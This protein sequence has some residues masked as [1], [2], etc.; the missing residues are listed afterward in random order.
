[1]S[2]I[3]S[4]S[5]SFPDYFSA[6][7]SRARVVSEIKSLRPQIKLQPRR[8]RAAAIPQDE[9]GR[10]PKRK[11]LAR[12][13]PVKPV[14]VDLSPRRHIHKVNRPI[15]SD[16]QAEP[17]LDNMRRRKILRFVFAEL[18]T[19]AVLLP[20]A[21]L[22][23]LHRLTDPNLILTANLVTIAAS[24]IVAVL[25]IVFFAIGPTLPRGPR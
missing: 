22:A 3:P 21:A 1:M 19:L 6:R 20:A 2:L 24:M 14:H 11:P 5:H 16:F 17:D 25:P 13:D 7:I 9:N 8:A 10:V 23:L 12:V 4:E 15:E 18:I